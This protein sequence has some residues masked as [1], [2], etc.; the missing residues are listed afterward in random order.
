MK[1]FIIGVVLVLLMIITREL[2]SIDVELHQSNLINV[3]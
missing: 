1:N 3:E 2:V